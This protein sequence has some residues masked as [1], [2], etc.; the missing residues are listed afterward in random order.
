MALG[1]LALVAAARREATAVTAQVAPGFELTLLD[2][3]KVTRDE[4]R[5]QVVVL[6][7]W[8]TWCVPCQAE[9]PLLDGYHVAQRKNA[10]LRVF[11]VTTEESLPA[12]SG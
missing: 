8:A 1:T 11:A 7:F 12:L 2:G 6:N 9:L 3:S 5:G 10:G 4:L